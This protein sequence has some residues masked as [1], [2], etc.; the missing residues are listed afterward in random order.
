MRLSYLKGDYFIIIKILFIEMERQKWVDISVKERIQ[1]FLAVLFGVSSVAI[2]FI[3]FIILLDVPTSIIGISGLWASVSLACIGISMYFHN[4]MID[5][6][7]KVDKKLQRLK[8]TE[9]NEKLMEEI[10]NEEEQ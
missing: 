3:S 5:F 2:G 9:E 4:Q 7:T 1:Y 10:E 6:Q 8:Y